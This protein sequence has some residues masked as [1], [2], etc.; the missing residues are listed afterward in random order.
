MQVVR[1]SLRTSESD[2]GNVIPKTTKG[3]RE[4]VVAK[5][6]LRVCEAEEL[7]E[8]V[9]MQSFTHLWLYD[10]KVGANMAEDTRKSIRGN[11][12]RI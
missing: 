1:E 11:V 5:D 8:H 10:T 3:V 2:T 6:V 4:Q 12:V 9:D 7:D